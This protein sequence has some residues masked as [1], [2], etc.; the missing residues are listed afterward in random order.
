MTEERVTDI[1][2]QCIKGFTALA[3]PKSS[4]KPT[5]ASLFKSDSRA[6]SPG[7]ED[8]GSDDGS[9]LVDARHSAGGH[10]SSS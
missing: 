4:L 3:S 8:W 1:I 7:I 2:G 10:S 6:M 9:V 5:A